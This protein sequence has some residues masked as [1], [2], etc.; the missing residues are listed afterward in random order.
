[1]KF[2][3]IHDVTVPEFIEHLNEDGQVMGVEEKQ[4]VL[5]KNV[6]TPIYL[7]LDDI[8]MIMP[9]YSTAGRRYKTRTM[10]KTSTDAYILNHTFEY[11]LSLKEGR[12]VKIGFKHDKI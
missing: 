4:K 9:Y 1:M 10:V 5:K 6:K 2:V 8:R 7:E 12:G 3:T 11:L